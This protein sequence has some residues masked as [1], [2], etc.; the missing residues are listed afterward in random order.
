MCNISWPGNPEDSDAL[1]V[2]AGIETK[3]QLEQSSGRVRVPYCITY[4]QRFIFAIKKKR[5]TS[6]G[7]V[8]LGLEIRVV[9]F[10]SIMKAMM[11][12]LPVKY[13]KPLINPHR[14]T[15]A[16][17]VERLPTVQLCFSCFKRDILNTNGQAVFIFSLYIFVCLVGFSF[18]N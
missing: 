17:L 9:D 10:A 7:W 15:V 18:S 12:L 2:F 4:S 5:K 16:R 6:T 11:N 1:N 3:I 14:A 13:C 8:L